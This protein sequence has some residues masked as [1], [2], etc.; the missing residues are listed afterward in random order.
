MSPMAVENAV[1]ETYDRL[2]EDC[3]Y[4]RDQWNERRREIAELGLRGKGIDNELRCLQARFARSYA[5]VRN[6]LRDCNGC[7]S[8]RRTDHAAGHESDVH[9]LAGF[10]MSLTADSFSSGV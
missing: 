7:E 8:A 1:C 4:A 10:R 3:E 5:L 9:L 2:V 6:H